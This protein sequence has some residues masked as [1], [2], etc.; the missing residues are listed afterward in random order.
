MFSFELHC[1]NCGWRTISGFDDAIGRLRLLGLLRRDREPDEDVVAELLVEATPRMTCP[2]C[3]EKRLTA[4]PTTDTDDADDWQ[5]AVLC[6][7]CRQPIDPERIEA[8]PN[9]KRCALCQS[10]AEAGAFDDEPEY[11]PNCGAIVETRVSRGS[12]ITRYKR[13]CT[14][15]PSCRL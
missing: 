1:S 12:G 14:G 5:A 7:V 13:V 6:E 15:V 8:I 2:L 9:T 4:D 10:K 3:K 11:C